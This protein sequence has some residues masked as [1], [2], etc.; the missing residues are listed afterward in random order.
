[1]K[2]SHAHKLVSVFANLNMDFAS[3]LTMVR[4]R[5]QRDTITQINLPD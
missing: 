2:D 4:I 5:K 1:M 3:I